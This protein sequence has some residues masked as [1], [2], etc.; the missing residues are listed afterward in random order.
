MSLTFL[1]F[2]TAALSIFLCS[3]GPEP[4]WKSDGYEVRWIDADL[5]LW[6]DLGDGNAIGRVMH[7]VSAV[8]DDDTWVVAERH[9]DGDE[10]KTEYYYFAKALDHRHKNADEIAKGPFT[11]LEFDK[12]KKDLDLPDFSK[13]F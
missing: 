13:H 2:F 12:I 4:K 3:C 1:V 5:V 8:G 9:P 6:L 10:T 11:K 7:K